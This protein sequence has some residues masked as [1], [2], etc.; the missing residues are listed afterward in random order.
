MVVASHAFQVCHCATCVPCSMCPQQPDR[1]GGYSAVVTTEGR[2]GCSTVMLPALSPAE[3]H[4]AVSLRG[5]WAWTL[6]EAESGVRDPRVRTPAGAI[7][8]PP[9]KAKC[10]QINYGYTLPYRVV[11]PTKRR[12][13][14]SWL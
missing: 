2:R 5:G 6:K 10:P 9:P 11:R 3:I 13:S 1:T 14:A 8:G 4:T 7:R 12:L